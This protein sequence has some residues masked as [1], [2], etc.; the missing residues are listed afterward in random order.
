M[1]SGVEATAERVS[2]PGCA[3]D[4]VQEL[5]GR[6]EDM[7]ATLDEW[8]DENSGRLRRKLNE[9]V[10]A[11]R[12]SLWQTEERGVHRTPS[13]LPGMLTAVSIAALS[14]FLVGYLATRLE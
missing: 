12:G 8:G 4:V 10:S 13:R 1:T 11:A 9:T 3:V 5:I 14:G 7:L 2:T 6:V